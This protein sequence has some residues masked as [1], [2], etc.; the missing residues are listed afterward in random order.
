LNKCIHVVVHDLHYPLWDKHTVYALFDF[1]SRNKNKIAG[2][3][4]AGDVFDNGCI[5]HHN[6]DKPLYRTQG[7]YMKDRKG[8]ETD[9]LTPLE[10]ILPKDAARWAIKGNHERFEDDFI[11]KHPELDGSLSHFDGLGLAARGWE[12]IPLGH[13]K[14]IGHLTVIHGEILTGIGNQAGLYPSRKAVELYGSN[15]LAGHTHSPQSYTRVSP[16]D[17]IRKFMGW[18]APIAGR[19]NPSY[20][21]NRP[22]AWLNGFTIVEMHPNGRNFNLYPV[23][24]TEGVFSYGGE[25]YGK[26][27]GK[28]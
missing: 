5:A 4:F 18:I 3:G 20:L 10:S 9:I 6:Q 14:V 25:I 8:F 26:A 7:A 27:K 19:T 28:K 15:V 2:F 12:L 1:L 22:T 24:V 23:I 13:A 16:V 11:E 21:R 17:H